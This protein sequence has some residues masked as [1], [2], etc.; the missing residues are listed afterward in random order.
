M[1]LVLPFVPAL[2]L[3]GVQAAERR[4]VKRLDF[5]YTLGLEHFFFLGRLRAM[6]VRSAASRPALGPRGRRG[7]ES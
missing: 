7:G 6:R 4:R 3:R 2:V 1:C 5:V